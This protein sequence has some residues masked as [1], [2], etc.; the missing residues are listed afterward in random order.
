MLVDFTRVKNIFIVCR[1]TDMR[2]G[3][4]GLASI[5]QYEYD[6]DLYDDAIFLFCGGKSDRFKALYWDGD[7]FILLYKRINDGKLKWPRKSVEIMKLSNQQLRW[8]LEGLSIIQPNAV[9]KGVKTTKMKC[10][11][12]W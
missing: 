7:G 3:I 5:V 6:M 12:R 1:R 8:L 11:E 9:K 4:D 10:F 2:K